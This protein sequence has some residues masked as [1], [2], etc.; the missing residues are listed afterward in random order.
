ML[1]IQYN[2]KLYK[3]ALEVQKVFPL[4]SD[5]KTHVNKVKRM[6]RDIYRLFPG[7]R[8]Y[9]RKQL[10][11]L[12]D[13]QQV[14]A[15][16]GAIRHLPHDGPDS[17]GYWHLENQAVNF[18]TQHLA[19]MVTGCAMVD[20]ETKMLE[21]HMIHRVDWHEQLLNDPWHVLASPLIDEIHDELLLDMHPGRGKQDVSI[22]VDCA[23]QIRT[24]RVIV[25]ELTLTLKVKV[26]ISD[27]WGT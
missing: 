8:P 14:V 18:P 24:L 10:R 7:I 22:L 23:E 25:P 12:A 5:W 26:H 15:A 16:T 9:I 4:S 6:R 13:T 11:E 2:M 19:S 3:T 27:S 21:A 20:Y 1:G 17:E